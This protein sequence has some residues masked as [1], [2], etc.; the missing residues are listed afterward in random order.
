MQPGKIHSLGAALDMEGTAQYN[1]IKGY[2]DFFFV[3]ERVIGDPQK[4]GTTLRRVAWAVQSICALMAPL[5]VLW[6]FSSHWEQASKQELCKVRA[7]QE[8]CLSAR[9][10][11]AVIAD[12]VIIVS[13]VV[14][15]LELSGHYLHLSYTG[16]RPIIRA[17]FY[18]IYAFISCLSIALLLL[19]SLWILLGV[20]LLPSKALP[21]AAGLAGIAA[22][23]ATIWA[24]HSCFQHKVARAVSQRMEVMRPIMSRVPPPLLDTIMRLKLAEVLRKEG[25]TAPLIFLTVLQQLVIMV[26]VYVFLFIAFAS[27]TDPYDLMAGVFNSVVIS[28]VVIAF[29]NQKREDS[30]SPQ[31]KEQVYEVQERLSQE[32]FLHLEHVY[33]QVKKALVLYH[34]MRKKLREEMDED[35]SD[36]A[37]STLSFMSSDEDDESQASGNQIRIPTLRADSP[38]G[39]VDLTAPAAVKARLQQMLHEDSESE[40]DSESD[41]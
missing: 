23:A 41:D 29:N 13:I 24:K 17:V 28:I 18:V 38:T 22:N 9:D 20:L 8:V 15:I 27:F 1:E 26:V 3:L 10:P 36:V 4:E 33:F 11:L 5:L 30:N 2:I 31:A 19:V 39:S 7:D 40:G 16:L 6:F 34:Q 32:I 37:E 25:L 14:F 12:M 21:Y 35:G